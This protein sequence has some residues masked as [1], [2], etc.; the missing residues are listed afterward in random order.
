MERRQ[1]RAIKPRRLKGIFTSVVGRRLFLLLSVVISA[2][3]GYGVSR[4]AASSPTQTPVRFAFS[5]TKLTTSPVPQI[6]EYESYLPARCQWPDGKTSI[7]VKSARA[8]DCFPSGVAH[9]PTPT[10]DAFALLASPIG[11]AKYPVENGQLTD[12][13]RFVHAS[14]AKGVIDVGPIL[15]QFGDYSGGARPSLLA[16]DGSIWIF[17]YQTENGPEVLRISAATGAVLQRTAM[18]AISRPVVAV[19]QYGF[20]MGQAATSLY[21]QRSVILGIW[22]A[23]IGA[24]QGVLIRHTD[25][26]IWNMKP[27]GK[28]MD[29]YLS[30]TLPLGKPMNELWRFSPVPS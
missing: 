25:G 6:G 23:P 8:V 16:K 9:F 1:S 27:S 14:H 26:V 13:I 20:W 10:G 28:S 21:A 19:N 24:S 29:V 3:I 12:D 11:G 17:D 2:A 15:M 7:T 5:Q 30:P 18:P 22:L 4:L